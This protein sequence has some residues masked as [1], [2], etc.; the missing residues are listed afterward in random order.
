MN[1]L[2][3][4]LIRPIIR[5][6]IRTALTCR[7]LFRAQ[8]RQTRWPVLAV[9]LGVLLSAC[10]ALPRSGPV[11][12]VPEAFQTA[13]D[14]QLFFDPEPPQP[15]EVPADIVKHF[16]EAMTATPIQTNVAQAFLTTDSAEQWRPEQGTI[17]YSNFTV[18]G[19]RNIV[20]TL[21][22]PLFVDGAGQW[23]GPMATG[24]QDISFSLVLERGEWRISSPL[25]RLI[26]PMSWFEQRFVANMAYYFEPTSQVLVPE[27][28]FVPIG[29]QQAT[30]LVTSLLNG[31]SA[32]PSVEVSYLP[33]S[34]SLDLPVTVD[35]DGVARVALTG[36]GLPQGAQ[37]T[38]LA[39]AQLRWTLRQ[40]PE[41]S[42]FTL[43]LDG[44]A[45]SDENGTLRV[46]SVS[47]SDQFSPTGAGASQELFGLVGGE[48]VSGKPPTFE[49]WG[50]AQRRFVDA[51]E[52]AVNIQG[53][54]MLVINGAGTQARLVQLLPLGVSD[55]ESVSGGDLKAVG[56]DLLGRAW[57]LDRNPTGARLLLSGGREVEVRGVTSE[58]VKR[59]LISR[60]GS[61]L[62]ALIAQRNRDQLVVA[63]IGVTESGAVT[64]VGRARALPMPL[65]L[66]RFSGLTWR[67]PTSVVLL[68]D[69]PGGLR[70][71]VSVNL[72]GS[73]VAGESFVNTI[74]SRYRWLSGSPVEGSS[75]YAVSRLDMI[76]LARPDRTQLPVVPNPST[77]RYAG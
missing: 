76:D 45:V 69:L 61:R 71:V 38:E 28:R 32:P 70:Q 74:A 77:L 63:R 11:E 51:K 3:S 12:E 40:V 66:A 67:S 14:S 2:T 62:V 47:G 18:S 54:R 49:P 33:E 31:P 15:G 48:L 44:R 26:V 9:T 53:S 68:G 72:D 20:V 52:V 46:F 27:R 42:A 58:V 56:W 25:D 65:G 57:L 10:V 1:P 29:D 39:V 37:D 64:G 55:R 5:P 73:I 23:R 4:P 75:L 59:A 60:D 16:L 34:A 30:L 6:I 21:T 41:V 8:T 13:G 36:T 22:D 35:D 19:S 17:V 24:S 50:F 7:V 43:E